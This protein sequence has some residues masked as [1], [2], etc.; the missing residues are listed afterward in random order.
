MPT[1]G[2][3]FWYSILRYLC[4]HKNF[5]FQSFWWR[6]C[7]WF[8]VWAPQS[9]ILATPML[10]TN[11]NFQSRWI[12]IVS[13]FR[14]LLCVFLLHEKVCSF[15]SAFLHVHFR[16]NHTVTYWA[17][18]FRKKFFVKGYSPISKYRSHRSYTNFWTILLSICNS[19]LRAKMDLKKYGWKSAYF[20]T[21]Q[22]RI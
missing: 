19:L 15:S 1:P 3:S 14:P 4:P 5:L 16:T 17:K 10:C 21:K 11:S 8:V 12:Y 18:V 22:K 7:M 6:Y 9:K 2:H 13:V 20:F